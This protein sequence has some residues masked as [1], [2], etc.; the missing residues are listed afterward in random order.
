MHANVDILRG[1]NFDSSLSNIDDT[2]SESEYRIRLVSL[3]QSIL[4]KCFPN[5]WA[6]RRIRV[7]NDRI[8][9]SCPYCG[10]SVKNSNKKRGNFILTGK[11]SGWYKCHNCG[12]AKRIDKFFEDYKV[13]LDLSIINYIAKGINDFASYSN[14][15]FDMSL[16]LDMDSIDEYAIDRQEFLKY[17]NLIE[18]KE[19][20]VWS[21]L[22]NRMQYDSTKFLY[23]SRLN[24]LII[25]NLT[26]SGK[27]LGLQKRTFKGPNKYL[28]YTLQKIYELMKKDPKK[29]PDEI[30]VLSQ[31]FNIC[32]IDYSQ[33]II[34]LEGPMD[35]F[36]IKN[37]IANAGANKNLPLDIP[38]K[39]LYDKDET[40]VK[41]SLENINHGYEVFLWERFL[42]DIGAPYRKK[43]DINDIFIWARSN[44][45]KV[46][47][48]L[49][50]F[51]DNPL[52]IIDL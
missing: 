38:L 42:K 45:I 23:N 10:D 37:S 21:W 28:T 19:S 46:P 2:V 52:D 49:N 29:I 31:I 30:N 34:L 44:N 3:L 17:F 24:H 15:K 6:K 1:G 18:V 36:L 12:E 9:F 48:I 51:S 11:Y 35:S 43:W 47:N 13:N 7:H 16:F 4:D 50:Y 20:P 8:N 22:K 26:P 33:P 32:L 39:Y 5:N 40:G 27:I 41:K 25:L 14:V